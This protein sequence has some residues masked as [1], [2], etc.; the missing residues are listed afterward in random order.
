[1]TWLTVGAVRTVA[2]R[3]RRG[4]GARRLFPVSWLGSS[5]VV[6]VV[7]VVGGVSSRLGY[8]TF[9]KEG[10]ILPAF[11]FLLLRFTHLVLRE[12]EMQAEASKFPG[13]CPV[14]GG[15][16]ARVPGVPGTLGLS[17]ILTPRQALNR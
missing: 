17:S 7:L 4:P 5:V 12:A 15:G 3:C 2:G 1:M 6:V 14:P 11:A 8:C 10:S 16:G 13:R 9:S